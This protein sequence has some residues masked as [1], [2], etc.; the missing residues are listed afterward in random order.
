MA[1]RSK[2]QRGTALL[3]PPEG[4]S[5]TAHLENLAMWCRW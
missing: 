4:M 2:L 5:C 1:D 3:L